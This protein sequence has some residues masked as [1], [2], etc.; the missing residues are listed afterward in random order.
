MPSSSFKTSTIKLFMGLLLNSA[1]SSSVMSL[2]N[3]VLRFAAISRTDAANCISSNVYFMGLPFAGVLRNSQFKAAGS[4]TP[5]ATTHR[6]PGFARLSGVILP[7]AVDA[8]LTSRSGSAGR[9]VGGA[10]VRAVHGR[11]VQPAFMQINH[12]FSGAMQ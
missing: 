4:P 1:R 10:F 2:V 9:A 12:K 11:T 3:A 6:Q 7:R 5:F 8:G